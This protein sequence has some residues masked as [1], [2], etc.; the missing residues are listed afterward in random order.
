MITRHFIPHYHSLGG[1][2]RILKLAKFLHQIGF[3][4]YIVTSH[5]RH[6]SYFGY[7]NLIE[8][9]HIIY[10]PAP[11]IWHSFSKNHSFD[12]A[13]VKEKKY[14]AWN[15]PAILFNIL[16]ELTVPD[17][18]IFFLN[19]LTK[20]A[21]QLIQE[22]D[23]QNVLITSPPHSTQLIGLKLKK[24]FKEKI[25]LLVDYRDSWNMVGMFRK[26][27]PILQY[28]NAAWEKQVLLNADHFIY[29]SPPVLKK[30]LGTV[31]DIGP[32]ATLIMNGFDKD[33][34]S[35]HQRRIE[36][37]LDTAPTIGYFGVLHATRRN[38]RNPNL[39]FQ[40]L[41]ESKK[42]F[43]LFLCGDIHIDYS[44]TDRLGDMLEIKKEV[45]HKEAIQLMRQMDL[46]LV[47]HLHAEG[48]DEVIP[49]KLFEYMLAERPILVVGPK[50]ME[51]A[52]IVAREKIGFC[53]DI[54]DPEDIRK[55]LDMIGQ[56]FKTGDV[57]R[58]NAHDL[59]QYSRQTQYTKLLP[60]LK[61]PF[62]KPDRKEIKTGRNFDPAKNKIRFSVVIP[63]Y[64][65][66]AYIEQA[67]RSV[68]Q[69]TI[70]DFE[71]IVIDDGSTDDSARRVQAFQ[72]RRLRLI[73]Q[74]NRGVSAA[75]NR[76]IA[77][78]QEDYIAFLDADDIWDPDFLETVQ[79]L[80]VNYPQ[81]GMFTTAYRYY[82]PEGHEWPIR[83]H[84]L[85]ADFT[86]GLIPDFFKTLYKGSLPFTTSSVCVPKKTLE[87]IGGFPQ[88]LQYTEDIY[89]WCRIV[90]HYP[91]AHTVTTCVKYCKNALNSACHSFLLKE[92]KLPFGEFL[93]QV[94]SQGTLPSASIRYA[95]ESI[96]RYTYLNAMRCLLAGEP[97]LARRWAK[98]VRSRRVIIH[99]KTWL[100]TI[101][102]FLPFVVV[103]LWG[104]LVWQVD[105]QHQTGQNK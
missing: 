29:H 17:I 92:T 70:Q 86:E 23:I 27:L 11:Y 2:I 77:E 87:E 51:A 18:G 54:H 58:Y 16:K 6:I 69:Q 13:S 62:K 12:S 50:N 15:G 9:F 74:G 36:R 25:N 33:M 100:V 59:M 68:L 22:Q 7:Q 47:I 102:S 28:F 21:A 37:S 61:P 89:T 55:K 34:V 88:D 75:R 4:I 84:G 98:Q 95:E 73:S 52:R 10:V 48:T 30:I 66:A 76:G 31:P 99:M 79:N 72:D 14:S 60:L 104:K 19:R 82:D 91:V 94:I 97:V 1:G 63:L 45:P 103:R 38:Y 5:G 105:W 67:L 43:K 90:V 96:A 41:L 78:A 46:L 39:F 93:G 8:K 65:K 44:W 20:A 64:N 32:K 3:E 53:M 24:I 42:K 26:R 57:P 101:L 85:P 83:P 71:I 40:G 81:A 80:I 56:C 35:D 49:G